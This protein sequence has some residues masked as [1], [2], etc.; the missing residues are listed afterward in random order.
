[1]ELENLSFRKLK[2]MATLRGFA[3]AKSH[4][5]TADPIVISGYLGKDDQFDEA[6]SSF[7][8]DY[9]SQ[10]ESDYQTY[11]EYIQDKH[12]PLELHSK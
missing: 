1:M 11:K 5:R 3:L 6:I 2:Q 10:N 7:S 4:A 12:L 9:A 8:M